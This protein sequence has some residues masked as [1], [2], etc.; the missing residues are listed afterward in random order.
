MIYRENGRRYVPIKFSVRGRDLA[1]TIADVQSRLSHSIH[2]P[3]GYHFE[4]AGE[5]DSLRK[6]QQRLAIIIPITV[7][8]ILGLLYVS[9]NSFRDALVVMSV[10]PFGIAGG[11]L[12]LLISRHALQHLGGRRLCLSDR[13]RHAWGTRLR[14]RD[15]TR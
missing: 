11:V 1:G 6:E 3:E 14:G 10:L 7:G 2:L 13:G 4:W 15:P 12:S 8:I 5:Y 9:F